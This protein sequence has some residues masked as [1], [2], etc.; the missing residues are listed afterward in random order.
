MTDLVELTVP[1]LVSF[2]PFAKASTPRIEAISWTKALVSRG[3]VLCERNCDSFA[4][5]QGCEETW[6]FVGS[7][8]VE[9]EEKILGV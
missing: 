7:D 3:V 2:S 1:V 9:V 6:T 8:M 4:W 5:R